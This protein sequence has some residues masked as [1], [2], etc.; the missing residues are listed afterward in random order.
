MNAVSIHYS[1]STIAYEHFSLLEDGE[2]LLH[3]LR[4]GLPYK[5]LGWS[6]RNSF[7]QLSRALLESWHW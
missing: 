2:A 5:E 7:P 6:R 4:R 1:G 3:A